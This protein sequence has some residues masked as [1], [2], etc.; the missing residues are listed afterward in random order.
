MHSAIN[1][2]TKSAISKVD[3]IVSFRMMKIPW[4]AGIDSSGYEK[5]ISDEE[6]I[7]TRRSA[8]EITAT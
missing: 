4:M 8:W 1:I 2:I 7:I 6:I 5:R 3:I